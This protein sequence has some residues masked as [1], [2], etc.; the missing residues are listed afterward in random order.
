MYARLTITA[1]FDRSPIFVSALQDLIGRNLV[2]P[3][4]AISLIAQVTNPLA[5]STSKSIVACELSATTL[6][7]YVVQ[8][9]D[10]LTVYI[11]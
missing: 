11:L 10:T 6:I 5:F 2:S 7:V 8:G 3:E 4:H 9:T 1:L